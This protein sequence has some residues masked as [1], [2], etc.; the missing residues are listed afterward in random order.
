MK[1]ILFAGLL[2][3]G[4][5]S[6]SAQTLTQETFNPHWYVQGQV[7]GQYTTGEANFNK[8]HSP[9]AQVA[10]GYQISPIWGVRLAVNGWQSRG[11]S[12]I[13]FNGSNDKTLYRWKWYYVAP[14]V[15]ATFDVTS[16]IWGF[17]PMR[18]VNFSLLAG[19]GANIGFKNDEAADVKTS[20]M[21]HFPAGYNGVNSMEYLWDGTKAR[22]VGNVGAS[23]DFRASK[24]VR[25]GLEVTFN[26]LSDHYNSKNG[27]A[28][29]CDHYYNALL[30]LRIDLGKLSNKV[31]VRQ[32]KPVAT[33]TEKVIEKVVVKETV[34]DTVYVQKPEAVREEIRRDIFFLIRGSVIDADEMVKVDDIVA[35]M[36][37]YPESK[38]T[39]TGYA[40]K[41]TG[42]AKL[43]IGYSQK[44]ANVVV[45]TLKKKG[46][47]ADR[48]VVEAKGDTEQPYA[49]NEKNRVTICIAR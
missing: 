44:R 25:V 33:A 16:L 20:I 10:A 5:L 14:A 1:K 6:A 15:D 49:E 45:D 46:I 21:S 40:D 36:K 23:V 12:E 34:H 3:L 41:G 38:V 13:G 47:A 22:L 48:I 26:P 32:E 37:K 31:E 17:N 29:K 11:A 24:R 8:L 7:G 43:N 19:L 27:S 4:F 42:N 30:G 39:V 35:Y 18:K 2:A 9:N 28:G